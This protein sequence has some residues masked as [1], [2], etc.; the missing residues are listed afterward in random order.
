M[1]GK[2]DHFYNKLSYPHPPPLFLVNSRQYI[3]A[4]ILT[5]TSHPLILLTFNTLN[6][7]FIIASLNKICHKMAQILLKLALNTNQS[8]KPDISGLK[9]SIMLNSSGNF[10]SK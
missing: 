4:I 3:H 7:D 1:T 10:C 8:I 5:L 2:N 9:W 6:Q